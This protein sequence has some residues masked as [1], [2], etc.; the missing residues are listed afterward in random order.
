MGYF[1][2]TGCKITQSGRNSTLT[3]HAAAVNNEESGSMISETMIA[4]RYW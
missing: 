3:T 2:D 4:P 1:L